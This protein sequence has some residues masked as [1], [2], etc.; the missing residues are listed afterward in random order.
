MTGT[1][2]LRRLRPARRGQGAGLDR[3]AWSRATE[4][5]A[6]GLATRV[7]DD[8]LA[9]ALELARELAAKSPDALRAGK[10]LLNQSGL[11]AD[12]QQF[13]DESKEMGAL[14][15]SP[16]QH[17]AVR[18]FLERRDA[19]VRRP[20]TC[21]DAR[22]RRTASRRRCSRSGRSCSPAACCRCTSSSPATGS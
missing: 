12:A 16:N 21:T 4:A 17:E 19:D 18:A 2:M 9:G 5:V 10:R 1:H 6:L 22:R 3:A 11:V 7:C 15:G 20:V 13:L 8:P 14:I